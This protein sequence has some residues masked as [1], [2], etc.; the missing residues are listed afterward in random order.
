MLETKIEN[1]TSAIERLI[2]ALDKKQLSLQLDQPVMFITERA[3]T[4]PD[5][6]VDNVSVETLQQ[7]CLEITRIDRANSAKIKELIAVYGVS[8]LKDIPVDKLAEFSEKL[9]ELAQ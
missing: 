2:E 8:L 3:Q 7:R 4:Q 6:P 1:L 9:E 5:T